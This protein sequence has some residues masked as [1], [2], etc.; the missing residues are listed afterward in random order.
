MAN[1]YFKFKQFTI[2]HD[3]CAMKTTTDACL[4]GAWASA[5]LHKKITEKKKQRGLMPKVLDVGAGTGLLSL[6]I[7][8]NNHVAID[9]VEIDAEAAQQA[10]ENVQAS[11]WVE[12][13]KVFKGDILNFG[14]DEY[15]YII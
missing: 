7:A 3:R 9:A 11:D 1:S 13:I 15:D 5:E 12:Q 6:M 14:P 10:K 8:Q 4:F 2:H